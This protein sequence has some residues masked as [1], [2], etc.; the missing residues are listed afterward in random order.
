VRDSLA[1]KPRIHPHFTP[2]SASWLNLVAVF[3][4]RQ[5]IHRGIFGSVRELTTAIRCVA[6]DIIATPR[7]VA[8]VTD[9]GGVG[10]MDAIALAD[11]V[12]F[13][14]WGRPEE[15]T[16]PLVFLVSPLS[17][18]MTGQTLVV[19]GGTQARF[20]HGGANPLND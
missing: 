18:F 14:R 16:G 3:I 7:V 5:A 11:G 13:G 19:D 6:P 8:G 17:G 4:E 9:S 15:I 2:T 10:Q 12:P 1:G 20:P